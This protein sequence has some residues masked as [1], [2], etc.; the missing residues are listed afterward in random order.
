MPRG[1]TERHSNTRLGRRGEAQALGEHPAISHRPCPSSSDGDM[2]G[3]RP[4]A[5]DVLSG[6]Y[7]LSDHMSR[8][9]PPASRV[10]LATVPGHASSP[11]QGLELSCVSSE[12]WQQN[13]G[14]TESKGTVAAGGRE[15]RPVPD[16]VPLTDTLGNA[17]QC[18]LQP[19]GTALSKGLDKHDRHGSQ[20]R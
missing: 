17:H 9:W 11:F 7:W 19:I 16:T 2:R 15:R 1:K 3:R 10:Q 6:H 14:G 13:K 12:L 20:H 4:W 18:E 5:R 8:G